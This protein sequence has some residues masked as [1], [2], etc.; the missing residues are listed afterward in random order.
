MRPAPPLPRVKSSREWIA[1]RGGAVWAIRKN[2]RKQSALPGGGRRTARRTPATDGHV[3]V[4]NDPA[5]RDEQP[6]MSGRRIHE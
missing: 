6:P 3:T 2:H 1:L 4:A 5:A